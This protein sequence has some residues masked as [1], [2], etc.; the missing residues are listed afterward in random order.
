MVMSY[1]CS[2][3]I[4]ANAQNVGQAHKYLKILRIWFPIEEIKFLPPN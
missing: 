1:L 4:N 3:N 2:A